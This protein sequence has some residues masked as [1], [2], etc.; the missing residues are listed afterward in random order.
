MGSGKTLDN[1]IEFKTSGSTGTPKVI[2]KTLASLSLDAH[3]LARTFHD[4]FKDHPTFVASIQTQHMYGQLWLETLQP[5]TGCPRHPAQIDGWESFLKC[6]TLYPSIIFVTT[7]SFLAELIAQPFTPAANIVAI[8]TSGSL[9]RPELSAAVKERFGVSPIEIYGSTETGSIAWRQQSKGEAWELFD[10]VLACSTD[11]G[12]L[13]V[14]SPFCVST[15]FTVQDIVTFTDESHFLLHGRKDRHVKILEHLVALADIETVACQHPYVEQAC[16]LASPADVA[17]IWIMIVPSEAGRDYLV[18]HG[19][20]AMIR[21]LRHAFG[22]V[23]PTY[24][25]PRRFRFVRALPYTAQGKLP[26]SVLLPAFMTERQEPVVFSWSL[27]QQQLTA[28]FAY[29]HDACFFQGHFP[30]APILPGVAQLFT[31][32]SF[33]QKAF[34]VLADGSIK[35]LKF[36]QPILPGQ[37]ITLT[38]LRKTETAFDFTLTSERG[39]CASG[40]LTV[41]EEQ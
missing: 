32:R 38:L 19:Y 10:E 25:V 12:T 39:P 31:V 9:L 23:L 20:Q 4:I 41:R 6:Q 22:S 18:T 33:I 21:E 30:N 8:I 15:P 29:P 13:S 7:P 17:R 36:Q 35:R 2:Q 24:A 14:T 16:A 3:L 1:V 28:V 11:E 40:M 37:R 26:V 27:Q 34:G 5:L